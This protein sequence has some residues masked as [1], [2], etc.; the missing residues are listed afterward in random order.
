[1]LRQRWTVRFS[2]LYQPRESHPLTV[3]RLTLDIIGYVCCFPENYHEVA[4]QPQGLRIWT[5]KRSSKAA[6]VCSRLELL[7]GLDRRHSSMR[8]DLYRARPGHGPP[9]LP[10]RKRRYA[11]ADDSCHLPILDTH[12]RV[13]HLLGKVLAN[14]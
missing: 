1:M 4:D 3:L 5:S 11:L 7:S 2:D 14:G 9:R 8:S 6:V 10:R 13:Q 12:L